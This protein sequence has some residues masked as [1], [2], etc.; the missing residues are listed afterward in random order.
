M[1]EHIMINYREYRLGVQ[2]DKTNKNI[3]RDTH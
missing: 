2:T 3:E 1:L